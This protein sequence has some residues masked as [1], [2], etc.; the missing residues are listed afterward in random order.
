MFS[1]LKSKS[2]YSILIKVTGN[3]MVRTI[4]SFLFKHLLIKTMHVQ[5]CVLATF[6]MKENGSS[7]I[8]HRMNMFVSNIHF[9]KQDTLQPYS[10][11]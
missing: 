3:H 8:S 11:S 6:P 4:K 1:N 7:V 10:I 9:E 5:K 2:H